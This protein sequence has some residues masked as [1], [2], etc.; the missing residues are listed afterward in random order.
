MKLNK[1]DQVVV[2]A[3]NDKG[4][5]G[6]VISVKD[7]R[8][9]VEGINVRK[10]HLKPNQKNE[11]GKIIDVEISIHRSNVMHFHED[12]AV[13]L[14]TKTTKDGEKIL[15]YK[16]NGQEIHYRTIKKAKS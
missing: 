16:H 9:V 11:K 14:K 15:Y 4:K 3:G 7:D 8:V 12:K 1:D 10:K 5:T 13:R 6:K 2:I